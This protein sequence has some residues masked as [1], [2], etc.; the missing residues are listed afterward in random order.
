[1][2]IDI[3]TI[4]SN[5]TRTSVVTRSGS[6]LGLLSPRS[7]GSATF[8]FQAHPLRGVFDLEGRP[9]VPDEATHTIHPTLPACAD[10]S[11]D[12]TLLTAEGWLQPG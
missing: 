8:A 2:R 4:D 7:G 1:M 12:Y 6:A 9:G 3:A 10:P 11:A 5:F